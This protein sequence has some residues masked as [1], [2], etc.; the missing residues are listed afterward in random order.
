MAK[1]TD[2]LDRRYRP[3]IYDRQQQGIHP[4]EGGLDHIAVY[5]MVASVADYTKAQV[6][7][8]SSSMY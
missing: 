7:H 2:R 3:R 8:A 6:V 1:W 5:T 4:R